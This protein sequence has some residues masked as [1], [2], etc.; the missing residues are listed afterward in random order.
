[1]NSH[2]NSAEQA[3]VALH[4]ATFR[5]LFGTVA[6]WL[7]IGACFMIVGIP[8]L[9]LILI[10]DLC[11]KYTITNQR[12]TIA[13]GIIFRT[14]DEIELYR[15]KDVK[16]DYS[17]LNQLFNI[18]IVSLH[19]TDVTSKGSVLQLR[20]ITDARK[21][22]ELLRNTVEVARR[23]RGVREIDMGLVG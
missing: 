23:N 2:I 13:K 9:L 16:V 3:L 14:V 20:Y 18:G 8:I 5:W 12:I 11:T 4:P 15:V 1:M 10:N 17:L 7:L 22:R 21:I 6:G 19:S